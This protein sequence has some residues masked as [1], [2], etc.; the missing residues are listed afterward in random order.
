MVFDQ[1]MR[2]VMGLVR[3][4]QHVARWQLAQILKL[5][6]KVERQHWMWASLLV[7]A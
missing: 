4:L 1:V 6:S 2:L 7:V 5:G 3:C